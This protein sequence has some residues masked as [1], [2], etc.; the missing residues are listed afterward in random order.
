VVAPVVSET[1][2]MGQVCPD[3]KDIFLQVLDI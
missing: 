2:L 1:E 3:V